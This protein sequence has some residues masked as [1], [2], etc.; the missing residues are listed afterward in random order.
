MQEVFRG[1]IAVFILLCTITD[2]KQR[3]IYLEIVILFFPFCF[4]YGILWGKATVNEWFLDLFLGAALFLLG[5]VWKDQMG[6][7]DGI[8]LLM[9]GMVWDI[10][11]LMWSTILASAALGIFG[12]I[13]ILLGKMDRHDRLPFIPFMAIS[14]LGNLLKD[15]RSLL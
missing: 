14:I 12:G 9:L 7:G 2:W 6:P 8:F 3:K 11:F 1:I 5:I 4:L 10:R 15:I 13:M